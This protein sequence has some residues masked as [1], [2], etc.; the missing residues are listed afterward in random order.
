MSDGGNEPSFWLLGF[1]FG[2]GLGLVIGSPTRSELLV[3][4]EREDLVLL[5]AGEITETTQ[6]R[7]CERVK[8]ALL[9][10]ADRDLDVSFLC[11]AAQR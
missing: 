11:Q 6:A 3:R 5:E 7:I 10:A 1:T 4:V 8:V 9:E 2:L